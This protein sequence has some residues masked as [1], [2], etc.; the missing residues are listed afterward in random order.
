M[1][2][3]VSLSPRVDAAGI[4]DDLALAR[5][6]DGAAFTRLVHPLRRQLR[7]HCYRMLGSIHDA[8]DAVQDTLIR[9]WRG[10]AGFAGRSSLRSWL[11]IVATR[12]CLDAIASRE[13]RFLPVDLRPP[14]EF[15][16]PDGAPLTDVDWLGPYPDAGLVDD[17]SGP[18]VRYEQREAI[19]L[20]FV[21]ALQHLPG[22]QRA[23]LLLFEVVGFSAAEIASMMATS[24]ASVNSALQRARA[25]LAEK[26]S[27]ASQQR[28]LRLIGDAGVRSLVGRFCRALED[29]DADALV[30][31]LTDD[32]TWAMPPLP[33]WY[34]GL[35]AVTDFATRMPLDRC[36]EWRHFPVEANGQGACASYLRGEPAGRYERWSINVLTVRQ[37]GIAAVTSFIGAQHFDAFAL[38]AYLA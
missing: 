26:V 2:E 30:R 28:T 20:A 21:A 29:G 3:I 27:D 10:L 9:A 25:V 8:D 36:G 15:A 23:A 24:R 38:P 32:V 13:R 34:R 5:A 11:Y 35:P 19:E 31:L 7:A 37:D 12:T 33:H 16:V 17:A 4:E 1:D 14:S 22:N 18:T 6:G